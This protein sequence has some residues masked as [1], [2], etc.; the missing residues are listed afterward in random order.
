MNIVFEGFSTA[1][2][3]FF[4]GALLIISVGISYWTYKNTGGLSGTV[5]GVLIS[6]RALVFV[7]LFLLL[8]NPVFHIE[9][10]ELIK[11]EIAVLLDNSQSTVIEKGEYAGEEAYRQVI[12]D[13]GLGDTSQVR[14]TTY[15]FDSGFFPAGVDTLRFNG[16]GTDINQ[17]LTGFREQQGDEQAVILISDGI[18]NRGRDPTYAAGR[19]T[20]PVFTVAL[21]D[22]SRLDDV[23]VQNVSSNGSGYKNTE[24]PA[25]ATILNNGFAD[26][27]VTVQLRR[28]G[29]VV[30]EQVIHSDQRQSVSDVRFEI[31]LDE[32]G[33]Q[34][35]EIHIPEIQGEWTTANNQEVFSIEVLDDK[36][37]IMQLA[38]EV[39][40]DVRSLRSILRED[41][42]ID[43]D[44]RTWI[45]GDRFINGAFPQ[46]PDTLDL[47]ILQGFPSPAIPASL[48][49]QV[50][51][52]TRELPVLFLSAPLMDYSLF[53]SLYGDAMPVRAES[54]GDKREIRPQVNAD[55]REHPVLDLPAADLDRAPPLFAPVQGLSATSAANVLMN[56]A[57]RNGEAAIPFLTARTA[58]NSRTALLSAH[59]FYRWF[60]SP[61]E[62]LRAYTTGLINNMV[63]WTASPP[64]SRLLDIAPVSNVF[65]ESENV[66]LDAFLRNETGEAEDDAVIEVELSGEDFSGRF[67]SMSN[68]GMG[69]YRLR[70]GNLPEGIYRFNAVAK[71]GN[72]AMEERSGEFSVGSTNL[73]FVNTVRNDEFLTYIAGQTGGAFFPFQE[74]DHLTGR[75]RQDGLLDIQIRMTG[76][77]VA[78]YQNPLWFIV[79]LILLSAEWIIRK[80]VA[81]P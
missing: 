63:K 79:I 38:F 80:V 27:D 34:Q 76:R 72:H 51:E 53:T 60:L 42:S 1:V 20:L 31:T 15:A 4:I 37:R 58:G 21:G 13:L 40:P 74:A 36:I 59:G 66:V 3:V 75:L 24:S 52:F 44:H 71:M 54:N 78:A 8:L 16:S 50:R 67:Y 65:E 5:R 73:E 41:D 70:I 6:L 39:H 14:F 11:P 33:L 61:D 17:A 9:R 77:D 18:F 12:D 43:L 28:D 69:Q 68:Q 49:E 45:S 64:D 22:T 57:F 55:H 35:Y 56:A 19:Y 81:L 7:I 25:V 46:N 23:V 47:I 29:Q 62:Q 30:D 10:E 26:T 48:L 2:N 32:V